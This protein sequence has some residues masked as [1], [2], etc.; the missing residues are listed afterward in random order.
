MNRL[1]RLS[2]IL[3]QLQSRRFIKAQDIATRF[4][5]S[6]RTVYRDIRSLENAGIPIIGEAGIGYS[7]TA[8]YRL[9]PIMFTREEATAFLTAEKLVKGLTDT[10]N[11]NIYSL[12]LDKIRAVLRTA[13]QDYL[14]NIDN[15]IEVIRSP[16][17]TKH[18]TDNTMQTALEAI[19]KKTVLALD[20]FAYYRQEH[21][22]RRVEPIGVFFLDGYWHLIAYCRTRNSIR[23]FRF[24]RI[25]AIELTTEQFEDLHGPFMDYVG[26]LYSDR[27][28][29]P[30]SIL[31][32][33]QAHLHLGEQRYYQGFV[34]EKINADGVQMDFM[35][36]SLEGFA[37][38]FMTFAD[39]AAV[40]K[41]VTLTD[42]IKEIHQATANKL[43]RSSDC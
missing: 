36:T 33:K 9:P 16:R 3:I 15:R 41:P 20:Y 4:E 30:V 10:V 40:M 43:Y 32:D 24:D 14:E 28:L 37:R 18:L 2:S 21:T 7:L 38:W 5:I 35:T 19:A 26:C 42:R 1:D 6:L 8:G 23:D 11:G 22:T 29:L 34:S 39:Y 25:S 17:S 13:E 27:S 31:V 12:A